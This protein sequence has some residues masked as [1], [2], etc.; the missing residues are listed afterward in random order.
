MLEAMNREK[1]KT[2][3]EEINHPPKAEPEPQR[4]T[5]ATRSESVMSSAVRI[6]RRGRE[7]GSQDS[8]VGDKDGTARSREREIA[9]TVRSWIAEREQR[10]RLSERGYWDMLIK[11]AQ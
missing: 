7:E 10:R 5:R 3:Q 8:Q 11:L 4:G 2:H 9:S 6:V 1:E